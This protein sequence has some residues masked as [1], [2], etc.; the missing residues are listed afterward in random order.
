MLRLSTAARSINNPVL[1][2]AAL[3]LAAA[4]DT[5]AD[6]YRQIYRDAVAG[7]PAASDGG[8]DLYYNEPEKT[9]TYVTNPV[10]PRT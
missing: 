10:N 2:V 6:A 4:D 3:D 8:F 1:S 5:T 9:L 7:S